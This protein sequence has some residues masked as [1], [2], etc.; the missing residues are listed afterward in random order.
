MGTKTPVAG[1]GFGV[2]NGNNGPIGR[3]GNTFLQLIC[4]NF[5]SSHDARPS[6]THNPTLSCGPLPQ[7]LLRTINAAGGTPSVR[8][9]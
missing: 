7:L 9:V 4:V 5:I 6:Y 1:E 2:W 8:S 3:R